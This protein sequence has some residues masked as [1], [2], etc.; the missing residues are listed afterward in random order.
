MRDITYTL[1]YVCLSNIFQHLEKDQ[2]SL[3][4]CVFVNKQWCMSA[5]PEL[6]RN[7]FESPDQQQI[8]L[9]NT[10]I[11]CLPHVIQQ[12]LRITS[13]LTQPVTFN[14]PAYI[15]SIPV[16]LI[17]LTVMEWCESKIEAETPCER[18]KKELSKALCRSFLSQ[19]A[20]IDCLDITSANDLNIFR[21]YGAS[22]KLPQ[23]HNLKVNNEYYSDQFKTISRL[24]QNIQSLIICQTEHI[25]LGNYTDLV[26]IV[27]AQSKL[28][29]LSIESQ[30]IEGFKVVWNGLVTS[31]HARKSLI[32]LTIEHI[33]FD[34]TFYTK[35]LQQ[36]TIFE[37]LERIVIKKWF[38][39]Q[40]NQDEIQ[41]PFREFK[42][43]NTII[44]KQYDLPLEILEPVFQYSSTTLHTLQLKRLQNYNL[45]R[46]IELLSTYC[47]NLKKFIAPVTINQSLTIE[48][49]FKGCQQLE[50]LHIYHPS[51]D[52]KKVHPLNCP[53]YNVFNAM[54]VDEYLLKLKHIFPESLR[55]FKVYF[56]WFFSP[57]V[58]EKF[59]DG[60]MVGKDN[61]I[62]E[63]C[64]SQGLSEE[65]LEVVKKYP[66]NNI[67]L[68]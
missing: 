43:L 46:V 65:H 52:F 25:K 56:I 36:L 23:I 35:F 14:Y 26:K 12:R 51:F 6:W 38:I 18:M 41:A 24:C 34:P 59:L 32:S 63:F 10:Y 67:K 62:L 15:R 48:E 37:N 27:Q 11:A 68:I 54:D 2:R 44:V 39:D 50:Y 28:Q 8:A 47:H 7:P 60:L 42:K 13:T 9:I 21:L 57:S 64:F 61:G 17:F 1:P 53:Q 55:T 40:L 4:S 58:L 30:N 45:E 3:H 31:P 20:Y 66:K 49:L 33:Y 19:A 29:N 5:I 16:N 22:S